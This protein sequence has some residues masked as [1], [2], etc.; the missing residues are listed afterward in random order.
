MSWPK[1]NCSQAHVSKIVVTSPAVQ[2]LRLCASSEGGVGSIPGQRTKI[3]HAM[4][5][6]QTIKIRMIKC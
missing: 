3:L 4:Q 6:G 5:H 1:T 2:R